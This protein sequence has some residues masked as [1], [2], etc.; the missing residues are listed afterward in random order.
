MMG[1]IRGGKE[2]NEGENSLRIQLIGQN[3]KLI[4]CNKSI[5]KKA[6]KSFHP[7]SYLQFFFLS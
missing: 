4:K 7:C 6:H 3:N 1:D 5:P 2:K